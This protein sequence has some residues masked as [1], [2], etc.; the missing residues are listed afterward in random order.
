MSGFTFESFFHSARFV[1]AVKSQVELITLTVALL[2]SL[3]CNAAV[4]VSCYICV[5]RVCRENRLKLQ[6]QNTC[7]NA[8]RLAY[9][10]KISISFSL[11]YRSRYGKLLV[12]KYFHLIVSPEMLDDTNLLFW[13]IVAEQAEYVI[14]FRNSRRLLWYKQVRADFHNAASLLHY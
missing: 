12:K 14:G 4:H 3:Q 13:C 9:T 1:V 8:E 7:A 2:Q 6:F 10:M 5:W 11:L